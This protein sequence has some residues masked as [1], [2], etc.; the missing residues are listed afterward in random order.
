MGVVKPVPLPCQIGKDVTRMCCLR[1]MM[2][3]THGGPQLETLIHHVADWV[4]QWIKN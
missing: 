3:I 1:V 2:F 4:E